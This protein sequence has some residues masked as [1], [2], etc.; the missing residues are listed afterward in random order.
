SPHFPE[1]L[2]YDS[3]T[4]TVV[5]SR[6]N[7]TTMAICMPRIIKKSS[8]GGDVPKGHFVVYIGE[9]EICNPYI[10]LSQPLFQDLLSQAEEEFGFDHLM[11]GVTIPC[12]EDFFC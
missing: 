12:S 10:I 7:V 2:S 11:G 5:I 4:V 3:S 8:T 6:L 9:E 1:V